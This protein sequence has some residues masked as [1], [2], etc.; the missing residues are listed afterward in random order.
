MTME[1][2]YRKKRAEV[3]KR[4]EGIKTQKED[5]EQHVEKVRKSIAMLEEELLKT[6]G[7]LRVLEELTNDEYQSQREPQ[8]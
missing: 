6:E 4:Y 3:R 8:K 2:S 7:E 5:L 1:D